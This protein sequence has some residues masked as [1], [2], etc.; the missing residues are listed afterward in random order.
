MKRFSLGEIVQVICTCPYNRDI[1]LLVPAKISEIE[2]YAGTLIYFCRGISKK[3]KIDEL[4]GFC[5]SDI[6]AFS[7]KQKYEEI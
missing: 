1:K 4:Q 5:G 6:L 7:R 2:A 3:H